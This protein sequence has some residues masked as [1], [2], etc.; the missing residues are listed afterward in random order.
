MKLTFGAYNGRKVDGLP[1]R[2]LLWLASQTFVAVKHRDVF[3]AVID[4]IVWRAETG[5]L[6]TSLTRE[7][8]GTAEAR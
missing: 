6:K 2:Y 5:Q 7:Q 1:S 4:E 8:L 3:D